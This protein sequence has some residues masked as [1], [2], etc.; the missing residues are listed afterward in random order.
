[1]LDKIHRVCLYGSESV[2][3]TTLAQALAAHYQTTWVPEMARDYLGD[4]KCTLDDFPWIARWQT[5]EVL[6]QT[7]YANR[8]L[9]CDTDVIT[10]ELYARIYFDT[11]QQEVL[12]LQKVV[13]YDLYLFLEADVP[14]VGDAQRDL[15]TPSVRAGIR[16]LFLNALLSR[17]IQPVM[18]KGDWA[19]RQAQAI[20]A[21][22]RLVNPK[23]CHV[24]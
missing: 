12:D 21:I 20:A 10:T 2:G 17:G 11:V 7:L 19:A 18:I 9:I 16:D 23:N 6:R 3:K 4:R 8:V 1:M 15:G 14:W 22:D 13:P 5:T 24:E